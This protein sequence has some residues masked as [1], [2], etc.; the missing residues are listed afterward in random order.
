MVNEEITMTREEEHIQKIIKTVKKQGGGSGGEEAIVNL[1]KA[2]IEASLIPEAA[3]GTLGNRWK[4]DLQSV[5]DDKDA[6]VRCARLLYWG[7]E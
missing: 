7:E 2:L 4:H 1:F 5:L 6:R 3:Y